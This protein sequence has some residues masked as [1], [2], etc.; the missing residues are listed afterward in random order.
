MKMGRSKADPCFY[1]AWTVMGL[2]IIVSLID[3]N[4][5]VGS[6]E[7]VM[8]TGRLNARGFKQIEGQHYEPTSIHAPVTNAVTIRV[9]FTLMLMDGWTAKVINIK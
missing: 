6:D 3:G 5:V 4:L 2:V 9:V 1:F 7:V 8:H